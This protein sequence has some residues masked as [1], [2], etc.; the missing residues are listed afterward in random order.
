MFGSNV[1]IVVKNVSHIPLCQGSVD[2]KE[3]I[4]FTDYTFFF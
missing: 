1:Q 3:R 4:F 2:V